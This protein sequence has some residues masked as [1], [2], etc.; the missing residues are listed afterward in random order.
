MAGRELWPPFGLE[1]H[2]GDP[3]NRLYRILIYEKIY[4]A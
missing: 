4:E 3:V 2:V 1:S